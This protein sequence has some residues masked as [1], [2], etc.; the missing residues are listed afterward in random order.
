MYTHCVSLEALDRLI[1]IE[2]AHVYTLVCG[3]TGER[4]VRLPIDVQSGC[5]ME[6][7]LLRTLPAFGVPDDGRFIDAGA[8]NIIAAF[9]PL[10]REDR[11]FM[12]TQCGR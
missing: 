2:F 4:C 1:H 3:T 5:A 12:L 10:Q 11:T 8:Q 7:E 9:I 6:T